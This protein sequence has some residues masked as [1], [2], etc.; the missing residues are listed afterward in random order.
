MASTYSNLKVQL[1]TTGENTSTW[2]AVTNINLGT[3]LEEAIVGTG[4]VTFANAN[5]ALTLANSNTSQ[6]ARKMRLN[7]IGTTNGVTRKLR[8]PDIQK[9]Y[10]VAN[11]TDG[12]IEVL[13]TTGANVSIPTGKTAWVYS[14]GTGVIS[15]V[16]YF[17]DFSVGES[18][19][20]TETATQ[21]LTNKTLT[22][23]V[24]TSANLTD[25]TLGSNSTADTQ[26]AGDNS[27][28]LATTAFVQS[29]VFPSGAIVLWSG[30]IETVPNGWA[31]CNGEN[32]TPDLRNRFVVG[33][34]STYAVDATGG[35]ADAVVVS[36]THTI[37]ETSLTG[38]LQRVSETWHEVG[39][40]SGVFTKQSGFNAQGTPSSTD[41]SSTGAINF[42]ATHTHTAASAGESGTNKNLPPYYALA[43]IMKL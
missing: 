43:Y 39:V 1:M 20:V 3:A 26:S 40:A 13:N 2:G 30:A 29:T 16:N 32:G 4:D 31:L 11:N 42:D 25:A 15:A 10:I 14:T 27:T 28:K 6:T 5:V 41:N 37:N 8:V 19:V 18:N 33:A 24:I 21:T 35:S 36:H 12:T 9:V 38:S 7:L 23:P 34:G 17:P 22:A